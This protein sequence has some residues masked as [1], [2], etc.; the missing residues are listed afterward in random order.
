MQKIKNIMRRT[1]YRFQ[2]GLIVLFSL[3]ALYEWLKKTID[4]WWILFIGIILY[5]I[6]CQ[7]IAEKVWGNS[8]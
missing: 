1:M 6:I 4:N 7:F 3:A 8:K 2:F 5:L